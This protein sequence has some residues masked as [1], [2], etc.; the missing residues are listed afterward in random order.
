M[1]LVVCFE[2]EGDP[3]MRKSCELLVGDKCTSISQS[4]L[5]PRLLYIWYRVPEKHRSDIFYAYSAA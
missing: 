3:T 5:V 2:A 1:Y 4:A